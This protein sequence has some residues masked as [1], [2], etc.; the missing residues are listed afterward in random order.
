MCDDVKRNKVKELYA[1]RF[2][3]PDKIPEVAYLVIGAK[4][5]EDRKG[6]DFYDN[7]AYYTLD[8]EQVDEPRHISF[9]FNESFTE[10]THLSFLYC[11][12]FDVVIFD[13]STYKLF[14]SENLNLL[15]DMVKPDGYFIT[16]LATL[17]ISFD[18]G[19]LAGLNQNAT[20]KLLKKLRSDNEEK[21]FENIKK[22]GFTARSLSFD[23]IIAENPVARSV[24][25]PVIEDRSGTCIILQKKLAKKPFFSMFGRSGGKR[26][27]KSMRKTRRCAMKSKQ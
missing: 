18:I 15:V 9:D 21:I 5:N 25:R 1:G 23:S 16:E 10:F 2:P 19:M 12:K 4:P 7:P 17:G 22:T 20:K 8:R 3:D 11:A 24:Y 26:N 14:N 6:R 27:K 13:H